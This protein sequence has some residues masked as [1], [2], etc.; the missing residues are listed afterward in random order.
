MKTFFFQPR[1]TL[2]FWTQ[3]RSLLSIILLLS[4]FIG[5]NAYGKTSCIE[6][7]DGSFLMDEEKA[8]VSNGLTNND[9]FPLANLD[10]YENTAHPA[11][12]PPV[13]L[14]D[15]FY[16]VVDL[17]WGLDVLANDS[18]A[19][20]YLP[21]DGTLNIITNVT[22]GNVINITGGFLYL[23]GNS[24]YCGEDSFEY[25]VCDSQGACAS[26]V[27][28]LII[29]CIQVDMKLFLA[30]P[31]DADTGMMKDQLR[32]SGSIPTYEPYTGLG[33]PRGQS[34]GGE[35]ITDPN[36]LTITGST[37]IVDWVLLEARDVGDPSQ[38]IT[39]K[40]ALI[41]RDGQVVDTNGNFPVVFTDLNPDQY[42]SVTIAVRHRNHLSSI[43]EFTACSDSCTKDF[44]T[45]ANMQGQILLEDG[46][47]YGVQAG[48][49]DG[50]DNIDANDRS[51]T[52]NERNTSGYRLSDV[53]MDNS[54]N[55]A[56][57]AITWNSRNYQI[58][59]P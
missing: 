6:D 53:N 28:T 1:L 46:I 8:M 25:E 2:C 44:T 30:G 49:A 56:D 41:R 31:F 57:R 16:T 22:N 4:I 38:I 32:Q 19:E 39:T 40:A 34:F 15:T 26:A 43:D 23:P 17:G 45:A 51:I 3:G 52:W 54:V 11:N 14:P 36:L 59:L 21:S 50:N 47:H 7:A 37:A 27:V 20:D 33:Y 58:T 55:A 13:A 12:T 35:S 42:P 5:G 9:L 29:R 10:S 18:D 24:G 48:S